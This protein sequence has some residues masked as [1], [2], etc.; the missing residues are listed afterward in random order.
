MIPR[1]YLK[2]S[3]V[4]NGYMKFIAHQKRYTNAKEITLYRAYQDWM[5]IL[6]TITTS[7]AI[8]ISDG[9]RR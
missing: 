4:R 2:E 5:H 6:N 9:L 7:D 1:A 8:P 3:Y